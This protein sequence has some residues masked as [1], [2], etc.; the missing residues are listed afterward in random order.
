MGQSPGV[1]ARMRPLTSTIRGFQGFGDLE[2]THY[3]IPLQ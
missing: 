1:H 2:A 3:T